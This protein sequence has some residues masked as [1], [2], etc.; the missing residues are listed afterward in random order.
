MIL[1]ELGC[2]VDMGWAGLCSDQ[3]YLSAFIYLF[4]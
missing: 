1:T 3:Q 4:I 2:T